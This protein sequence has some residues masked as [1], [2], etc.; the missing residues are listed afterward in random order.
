MWILCFSLCLCLQSF[1]FPVGV[2]NSLPLPHSC[3]LTC[4]S[5]RP[6]FQEPH[7]IWWAVQTMKPSVMQFCLV[8]SCFLS[9]R[10]RCLPQ[11]PLLEYPSCTEPILSRVSSNWQS[12][13]LY[14]LLLMFLDSKWA[15]KSRAVAVAVAVLP[16]YTFMACT[17]TTVPRHINLQPYTFSP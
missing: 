11:H 3:Y 2:Q 6:S 10:P 14:I 16:P 4:P 15:D 5:Y 12:C 7:Y 17:G 1:L 13:I 9:L 8:S